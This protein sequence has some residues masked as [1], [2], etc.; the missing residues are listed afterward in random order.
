MM[1]RGE[2]GGLRE[3]VRNGCDSLLE[4][5]SDMGL[6]LWKLPGE[7]IGALRLLFDPLSCIML[8]PLVHLSQE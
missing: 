7:L 8:K 1:V 4:I 2:G 3:T 6:F 5:I